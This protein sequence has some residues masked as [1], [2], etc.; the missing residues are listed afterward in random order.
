MLS[1]PKAAGMNVALKTAPAFTPTVWSDLIGGITQDNR[2][3]RTVTDTN[4]AG[5]EKFY[6]IEIVKP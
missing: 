2:S 1:E 6:R 4:A 3:E 5:E